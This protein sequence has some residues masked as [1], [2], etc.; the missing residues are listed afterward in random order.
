VDGEV[1]VERGA[2][3]NVRMVEKPQ[4]A[5]AQAL[6]IC[7]DD[8]AR[9]FKPSEAEFPDALQEIDAQQGLG[10]LITG[11]SPRAWRPSMP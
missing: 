10:D 8:K 1:A 4:L 11:G 7:A 6:E 5:I 3:G 2:D 9:A